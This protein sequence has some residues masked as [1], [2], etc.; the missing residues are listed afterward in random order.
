M[1]DFKGK[2]AVVTGAASGIGLALAERFAGEGMR[3]VL[4]DVERDA[5]DAAAE[6]A[7]R[8]AGADSVLAVPTDVRDEQAV[9]ALAAATVRA[10]RHRPRG[11]QQRRRGRRRPGA[12]RSPPTGGAGSSRSTCSASPTASGPSCPA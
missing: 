6:E 12:G 10:V 8:R 2:V 3:V 1:D 5:L 11:V 9:D 4:A 7:G